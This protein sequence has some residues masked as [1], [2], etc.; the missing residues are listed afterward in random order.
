MKKECPV[1]VGGQAVLEGV[2]MRSGGSIATAVRSPEGKIILETQ[3]IKSAKDNPKWR[4]FPIIR[5]I[6]S[7]VSSLVIGMKSISRTGEVYAGNE[8]TTKFERWLSKKLKIDIMD[9]AVFIGIVLGL[10]LAVLLFVLAPQFITDGILKLAKRQDTNSILKN[11]LAGIVRILIFLGY[12]L[13]VSLIKD[14]KRLFAYHGAEH[15]VINCYE[16]GE[17]LTPENA[18]KYSTIHDR[19]GTSFLF[20]V[21]VVSILFFSFF[22]WPNI[23]IRIATRILLLPIVAGLSYEVL[24]WAAKYDNVFVRIIKAPGKWLQKITTKEP[25]LQMLEVSI[26]AFC[27]VMAMEADPKRPIK[28]FDSVA[29]KDALAELAI[30]LPPNEAELIL[31]SVLGCSK[32]SELAQE[33]TISAKKL[34]KAREYADRRTAGEP[35]QYILGSVSFYGYEIKVTQDVLIPRPETELLAEQAIKW[36]NL[37]TIVKDSL[38]VLELATGSGAVAIAVKKQVDEH[39]TMLG[40]QCSINVDAGDISLQALEVAGANAAANN[41]GIFFYGGDMFAPFVGKKY[42]II[43]ANPPYISNAEISTLDVEVKDYEPLLALDGGEDGLD[44]Y[45]IIASQGADYLLKG[46]CIF[47]EIGYTQAGAVASLF[48]ENYDVA[49]IKDF[50]G[51]QRIIKACKRDKN[52]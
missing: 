31:M 14:I 19:C 46:G 41:V 9:I 11:L 20:L 2:M 39:I 43:V 45:R 37:A 30:K 52:V 42:D 10:G 51:I 13:A 35:L 15:K 25:D 22:G 50:A 16:A 36:L 8:Q 33:H 26:C 48:S 4:S 32:R 34:E 12:I 44:F 7:F 29:I 1:S 23:W 24:K 27:E 17:E 3:R 49:I 21:L 47:L 28:N 40:K 6:D 38:N 18:S 5:G